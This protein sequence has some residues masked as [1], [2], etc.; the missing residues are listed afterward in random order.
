VTGR[1]RPTVLIVDDEPQLVTLV[2]RMLASEGYDL[3]TATSP[4]QALA[5]GAE[6]GRPIDLLL[7]DLCMPEMTGR[8]L[9]TEMRK[10]W[11][12]LRVLYLTG[13]S[14]DLFG[15]TTELNPHEAFLE[16]PI[17]AAAIREAV[18]LHLYRTLTPPPRPDPTLA[19]GT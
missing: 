10:T 9:A 5:T 8:M 14:D 7:S 6:C 19:S 13:Y 15:T 18:S 12:D 16:K 17:T 4:A 11:K 1:P 3:L 2:A